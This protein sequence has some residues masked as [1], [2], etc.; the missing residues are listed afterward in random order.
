MTAAAEGSTHIKT[1]CTLFTSWHDN[2]ELS[3]RGGP[4]QHQDRHQDI[5]D[6]DVDIEGSEYVLLR[7]KLV[8]VLPANQHLY[9]YEQPLKQYIYHSA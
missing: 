6:V 1:V 2:L 9:V 7:V 8:L 4:D 3:V 5:D